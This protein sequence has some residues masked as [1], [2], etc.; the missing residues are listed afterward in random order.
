MTS[1]RRTKNWL[2]NI[3]H[4][5]DKEFDHTAYLTGRTINVVIE[6]EIKPAINDLSEHAIDTYIKNGIGKL[7]DFLN[8]LNYGTVL[9]GRDIYLNEFRKYKS[10][11]FKIVEVEDSSLSGI[12]DHIKNI[13][14]R[15][16]VWAS[17]NIISIRS[18]E[19]IE[20]AREL[21][22]VNE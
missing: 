21:A 4:R 14:G 9:S 18:V 3:C 15:E 16:L 11:L 5:N 8:D 6:F 2:V 12:A 1:V 19:L 17:D 7:T 13:V 20:I 22:A 10:I